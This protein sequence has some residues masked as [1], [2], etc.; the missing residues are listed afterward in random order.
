MWCEVCPD[1]DIVIIHD[2]VRPVVNEECVLAVANAANEHGVS[3]VCSVLFLFAHS[4]PSVTVII[5]KHQNK[6]LSFVY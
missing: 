1:V 2:A 6:L 3:V 5:P 4:Y